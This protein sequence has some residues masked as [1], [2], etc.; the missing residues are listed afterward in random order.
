MIL[1]ATYLSA[2]LLLV[3]SMIC[4]GSWANTFKLTGENWRFEFFSYD[5]AI[6]VLLG[7]VIA[8]FTFGTLGSELTFSDRL[9]IAGRKAELFVFIGGV[10]FTLANML[11][12]AAI[13]LAGLA[14]AFP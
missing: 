14:V 1:P 4:W 13:S 10:V 5:F 11:L 7:A 9:L 6:G 12:M 8:A 3:V 2:L